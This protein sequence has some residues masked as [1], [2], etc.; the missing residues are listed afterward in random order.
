MKNY[1]RYSFT[2]GLALAAC[3]DDAKSQPADA[4]IIPDG[5]VTPD[6][7]PGDATS[8]P[9]TP[10]KEKI[11]PLSALGPDQI[12]SVATAPGGMFYIGGFFATALAGPHVLTLLRVTSA[13]AGDPLYGNGGGVAFVPVPA[14]FFQGGDDEI[15]IATQADGKIVMSATVANPTNPADH[16]IA[17]IRFLPS[18]ELD[19]TFGAAK[20]G[21]VVVNL[22]DAVVGTGDLIGRDAARGLAVSDAGIFVHAA[23]R[24]LGTAPGGGDRIDTDFTVVKLTLE[25]VVDETFGDQTAAGRK[26]QF[27][28]D[29]AGSDADVRGIVAFGDGTLVAVGS[30]SSTLVG[31]TTQ[32]VIYKLTKDGALDPSFHTT[33]IFHEVVLALQTT[34]AAVAIESGT[35]VTGGSGRATGTANQ[36]VSLRLDAASG[37]RDLTWGGTTTGNVAFDP[38]GS[39]LDSSCHNAVALPGG[40]TL[41]I[42]STGP[43]NQANQDAVFAVLDATGKL[44]T[45]YGTGINTYKFKA[46]ATDTID[47]ADQFWGAAVSGEKFGILGYR[48]AGAAQTEAAND[49]SFGALVDIQ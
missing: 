34:V 17:V 15:D 9:Y 21:F 45:A 24:A 26:G 22:N 43:A 18:G 39:Q 49:D 44:D 4:A 48:G 25:G 42:G 46:S 1:L 12:Q 27:R 37:V 33:G 16:D 30:A 40:K 29:L 11:V 28:L 2:L 14:V 3:G 31:G 7:A 36:F 20:T 8:G 47:G 23:S 41:L 38:S 19:K 5:A 32:P 6:A 13:G 35:L 10:A